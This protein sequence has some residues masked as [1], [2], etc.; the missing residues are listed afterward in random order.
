QS[1]GRIDPGR[2]F[3]ATPTFHLS[4]R[5]DARQLWA[6]CF[7]SALTAYG[8]APSLVCYHLLSTAFSSPP[9]DRSGRGILAAQG[10]A[11]H[12]IPGFVRRWEIR[13]THLFY[14]RAS[15]KFR[16]GQILMSARPTLGAPTAGSFLRLSDA[17]QAHAPAHSPPASE[18]LYSSG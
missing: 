17:G 8:V 11:G 7:V 3:P 1:T 6:R 9:P 5:F 18:T 2:T 4:R 14:D 12:G 13:R 15:P 16:I 10:G